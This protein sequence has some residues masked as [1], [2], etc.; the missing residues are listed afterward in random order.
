MSDLAI[1]TERDD[2]TGLLDDETLRPPAKMREWFRSDFQ[3]LSIVSRD[4]PGELARK[5][6]KPNYWS[7][8]F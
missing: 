7:T 8:I 6:N 3:M 2:L 4:S 5:A 1:G